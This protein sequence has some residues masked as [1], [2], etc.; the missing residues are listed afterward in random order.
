[1]SKASWLTGVIKG[2]HYLVLSL[3]P[4]VGGTDTGIGRHF[5]GMNGNE[6]R[7]YFAEYI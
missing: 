3:P 1:M 4:S 5:S 2:K 6:K 7:N